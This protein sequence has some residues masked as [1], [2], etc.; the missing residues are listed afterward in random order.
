MVGS[1]PLFN[2]NEITLGC[3]LYIAT[4]KGVNPP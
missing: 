1:A 4:C 2:N 3:P